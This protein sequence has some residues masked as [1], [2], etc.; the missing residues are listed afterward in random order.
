MNLRRIPLPVALLAGAVALSGCSLSFDINGEDG[1]GTIVS[2]S[3][4]VDAFDQIDVDGVFDAEVTVAEGSAHSVEIWTDDNLIDEIEVEVVD[5]ELRLSVRDDTSI[6]PTRL[7]AIIS[8]P[9]LSSVEADGAADVSA[10]GGVS[11]ASLSVEASGA[12]TVVIAAVSVDDLEI[13]TNGAST[14]KLDG[15]T[16]DLD[17]EANGASSIEMQSFDAVDVTIDLNGASSV[18]LGSAER[19]SGETNGASSMDI[20]SYTSLDI[21]TNGVSSVDAG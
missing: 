15:R 5:G 6:D 4:A 2:E 16:A 21:D 12:S 20:G 18:D 17:I 8:M 9:T 10:L 14:V 19:V 11:T 13:E 7:D 3:P 1:S